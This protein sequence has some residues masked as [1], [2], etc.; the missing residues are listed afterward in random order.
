VL[1]EEAELR[2]GQLAVLLDDPLDVLG[3]ED[4]VRGAE[5]PVMP[6][7]KAMNAPSCASMIRI[8]TSRK[9]VV[10][11]ARHE[12]LAALQEGHVVSDCGG[13]SRA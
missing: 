2:L 7:G 3:L 9:T 11:A 8:W 10:T 5:R 12:D 6:L 1:A 4:R 13:R